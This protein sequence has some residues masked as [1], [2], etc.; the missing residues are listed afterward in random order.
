MGLIVANLLYFKLLPLTVFV[1]FAAAAAA[2]A[3]AEALQSNS[4]SCLCCAYY[5][6]TLIA[7]SGTNSG[8]TGKWLQ[9]WFKF[10][11]KYFLGI[12]TFKVQVH[13][14]H[15]HVSFLDMMIK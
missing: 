8:L 3:E 10:I 9:D 1:L 2:A 4:D 15:R 11:F 5:V 13:H 7:Q 6:S 14:D 12:R